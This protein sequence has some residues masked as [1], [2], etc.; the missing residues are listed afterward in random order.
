[1]GRGRSPKVKVGVWGVRVVTLTEKEGYLG[2]PEERGN[3]EPGGSRNQK[4][5]ICRRRRR[6]KKDLVNFRP[7]KNNNL[8]QIAGSKGRGPEHVQMNRV[9][10]SLK[11]KG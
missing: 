8:G 6:K 2:A 1:M 3:H 4:N 5:G 7:E 10:K 11:R 9:L